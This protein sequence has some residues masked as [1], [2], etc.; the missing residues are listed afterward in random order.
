MK[1]LQMPAHY[2]TMGEQEQYHTEGGY[3]FDFIFAFFGPF[4]RGLHLNFWNSE[5]T[6]VSQGQSATAVNKNVVYTQ[7]TGYSHTVSSGDSTSIG[8]SRPYSWWW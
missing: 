3:F 6:T 5:S 4:F 1:E 2:L 8:F 7:S